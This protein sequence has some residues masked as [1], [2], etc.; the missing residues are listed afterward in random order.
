MTEKEE[1]MIDKVG[2]EEGKG[3]TSLLYMRNK[4]RVTR[5][6]LPNDPR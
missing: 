2:K 3:E 1:W 5:V 4:T 6:K